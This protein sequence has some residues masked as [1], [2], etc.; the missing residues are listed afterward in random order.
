MHSKSYYKKEIIKNVKM[1]GIYHSIGKEEWKK[2]VQRNN[3]RLAEMSLAWL[4]WQSKAD[5]DAKCKL[6]NGLDAS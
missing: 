2:R 4:A 1:I 3:R 6:E 5:Q